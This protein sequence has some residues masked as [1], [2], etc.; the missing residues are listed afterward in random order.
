MRSIALTVEHSIDLHESMRVYLPYPGTLQ[1]RGRK[2]LRLPISS[3]DLNI[4]H[5]A[6]HNIFSRQPIK[7]LIRS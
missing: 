4:S 7:K 5:Y 3:D 1:R 6:K 2:I